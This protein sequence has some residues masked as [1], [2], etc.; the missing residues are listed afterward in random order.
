MTSKQT[1]DSSTPSNIVNFMGANFFWTCQNFAHLLK[2]YF[3]K[4]Q[5]LDMSIDI[6]VGVSI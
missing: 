2:C 4:R 3:M 5:F 1:R 6:F